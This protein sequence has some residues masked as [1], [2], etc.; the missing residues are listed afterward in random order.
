MLQR[1]VG[2]R[3]RPVGGDHSPPGRRRGVV[4]N[5]VRGPQHRLGPTP[6]RPADHA[7]GRR[8]LVRPMVVAARRAR[9]TPATVVEQAD[10]WKQVAATPAATAGGATRGRHL[11]QCRA[12]VG[13]SWTAETTRMLLG[14][15][16]AAFHAG[17][18]DI[19]LIAFGLACRGVLGHRPAPPIGIDVEGHGRARGAGRRAST[20]RAPWG[21]SPPN[22]RWR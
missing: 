1:L 6:Q 10:T 18:Q 8:H 20:C 4:A 14:E 17:V 13:V 15:V 2:G 11:C 9:R 22:T 12:V 5:P 7:A 19:L 3:H 21:G 16:P